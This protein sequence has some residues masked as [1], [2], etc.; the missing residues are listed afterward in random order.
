MTIA[1][2]RLGA[3][4]TADGSAWKGGSLDGVLDAREIEAGLG[5]GWDVCQLID[6]NVKKSRFIF[7][8]FQL[9]ASNF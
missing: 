6:D 4:V 3:T 2:M 5:E 7:F 8:G 1:D 9:L